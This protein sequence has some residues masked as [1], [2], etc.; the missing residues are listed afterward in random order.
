[1]LIA[2]PG[3]RQPGPQVMHNVI[4]TRAILD[5]QNQTAQRGRKAIRLIAGIALLWIALEVTLWLTTFIDV[6][7]EHG[8]N[9]PR[10]AASGILSSLWVVPSVV[11][12]ICLFR[13]YAW[14]RWATIAMFAWGTVKFAVDR[15][16]TTGSTDAE[17]VPA[18]YLAL[19]AAALLFSRHIREF[20]RAQRIGHLDSSAESPTSI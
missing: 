7:L 5:P 11:V 14:A 17:M 18:I 10:L 3:P 2:W 15:L 1:M 16:A 4:R 19:A 9:N 13:G 8:L 6:V 12:L 20:Y